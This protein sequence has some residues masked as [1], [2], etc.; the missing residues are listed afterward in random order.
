MGD[1]TAAEALR[2]QI[3]R[4]TPREVEGTL[5]VHELIGATVVTLQGGPVGVV[6]AVETNPASDLLV[7]EDG[8]L[9]P[10]VFVVEHT[11]GERIVVDVPDGLLD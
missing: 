5:W 9:I 8:R 10:V 1:R 2:G 4:A 11:A 6:A 7:L 3:L